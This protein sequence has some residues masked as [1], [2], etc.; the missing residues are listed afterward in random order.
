MNQLKERV[1][2]KSSRNFNVSLITEIENS[3]RLSGDGYKE[4]V[5]TLRGFG[6]F[7]L[8]GFE[9]NNRSKTLEMERSS[10]NK[11]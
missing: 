11:G 6:G 9:G 1:R 5:K 2:I 3:H 7:E 4:K 10:D 8:T